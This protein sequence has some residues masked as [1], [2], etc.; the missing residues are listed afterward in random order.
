VRALPLEPGLGAERCTEA[1]FAPG[2]PARWRLARRTTNHER[3]SRSTVHNMSPV[4]LKRNLLGQNT[5][6]SQLPH[7]PTRNAHVH[8]HYSHTRRT[9]PTTFTYT[10]D[11]TASR[12]R[13]LILKLSRDQA[14]GREPV[15]PTAM[16]SQ[17]TRGHGLHS[18]RRCRAPPND[19]R[20]TRLEREPTRTNGRLASKSA[21]ARARQLGMAARLDRATGNDRPR[22]RRR[23]GKVVW[24]RRTPA[25]GQRART[26]RCPQWPGVSRK[27]RLGY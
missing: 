9:Q 17:R 2:G 6:L 14:H 23:A 22:G 5:Q 8:E 16:H 25:P 26:T 10:H 19:E 18:V 12:A 15:R 1:Q 20:I 24:A 11:F 3:R 27:S 21:R 13:A 4:L 7:Q